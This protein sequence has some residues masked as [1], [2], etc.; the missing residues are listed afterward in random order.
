[1][2]TQHRDTLDAFA[3][4]VDAKLG[5]EDFDDTEK[6]VAGKISSIFIIIFFIHC[7]EVLT[8]I[9][10]NSSNRTVLNE[11][12]LKYPGIISICTNVSWA[13]SIYI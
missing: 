11:I 9:S 1:M 6:P 2:K 3:D 10:I 7:D 13:T 12:M 8:R 5:L 4:A